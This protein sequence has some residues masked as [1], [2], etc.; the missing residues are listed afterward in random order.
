M[1][2]VVTQLVAPRTSA[3]PAAVCGSFFFPFRGGNT[4]E[5]ELCTATPS[6]VFLFLSSGP[7]VDCEPINVRPLSALLGQ[8]S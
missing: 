2:F 8:L 1:W 3:S 5:D 6:P 4:A 7:R